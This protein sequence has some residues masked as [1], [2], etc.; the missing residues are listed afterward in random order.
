MIGFSIHITYMIGLLFY[1]EVAY[2]NPPAD[3][4]PHYSLGLL[5]F[6]VYPLMYEMA[7]LFFTGF[8]DYFSDISNYLDMLYLA[9]SVALTFVH[10]SFGPEP[11]FSKALMCLVGTLAFRRTMNFLRILS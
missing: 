1:S 7:Q 10:S 5:V 2:T 9:S 6:I 4:N 8:W 3:F 11:P